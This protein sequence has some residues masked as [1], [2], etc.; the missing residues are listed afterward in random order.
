[1]KKYILPIIIASLLLTGCST[2]TGEKI[3]DTSSYLLDNCSSIVLQTEYDTETNQYTGS[4][5]E[6][7]LNGNIAKFYYS[8]NE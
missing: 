4:T 5:Y 7:Y 1:M 8:G 3:E 2:N 6:L